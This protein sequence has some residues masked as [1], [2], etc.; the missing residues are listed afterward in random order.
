MRVNS[1]IVVGSI[2]LALVLLARSS[3]SETELH[4]F[5][6]SLSDQ[7]HAPIFVDGDIV[8]RAATFTNEISGRPGKVWVSY[9]ASSLDV[10]DPKPRAPIW[11]KYHSSFDAKATSFAVAGYTAKN[12]YSSIVDKGSYE[13]LTSAGLKG[14]SVFYSNEYF[15]INDGYIHTEVPK[16]AS[17]IIATLWGGGNDLLHG[18]DPV[19]TAQEISQS[20]QALHE[21]ENI[22]CIVLLD[23]PDLGYLPINYFLAEK[24]GISIAELSAERS[25]ISNVFNAQL[26]QAVDKFS[27]KVQLVEVSKLF[28]K[29]LN[30]PA[31]FGFTETDQ[32][33]YCIN[34]ITEPYLPIVP[35]TEYSESEAVMVFN[36]GIHPSTEM[37]SLIAEYVYRSIESVDSCQPGE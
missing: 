17:H 26:A 5:G 3:F 8:D 29:V 22:K 23:M 2:A 4:V 27:S 36:D 19:T 13:E 16:Q 10:K 15:T 32:S 1:R 21:I 7:G 11:E 9:L 18:A 28:A 12:I 14:M 30:N 33:R 35:C 24:K 34:E 6:D 20:L 37:H 25:D 31:D